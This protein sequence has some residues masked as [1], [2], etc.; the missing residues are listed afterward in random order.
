M[1]SYSIAQVFQHDILDVYLHIHVNK[2]YFF[3]QKKFIGKI[4]SKKVIERK[5][6]VIQLEQ[7]EILLV[8]RLLD[9]LCQFLLF[10]FY[11]CP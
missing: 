1:C 2:V 10:T 4:E 9:H 8:K 5:K 7:Q 11:F 3:K 6:L